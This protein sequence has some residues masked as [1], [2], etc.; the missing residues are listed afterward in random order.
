MVGPLGRL[1]LT[2]PDGDAIPIEERSAHEVTHV[3]LEHVTPG[4]TTVAN[5]AFDVTPAAYITAIITEA[6]I[7]YPPYEESLPRLVGQAQR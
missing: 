5:P 4:G 1:N 7:A 3:G 2:I 6:G